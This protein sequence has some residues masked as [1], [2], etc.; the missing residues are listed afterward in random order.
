MLHHDHQ[1]EAG[2]F[3]GR[4]CSFKDKM[5]GINNKP[6]PFEDEAF[7]FGLAFAT[8]GNACAANASVVVFEAE[9]GNQIGAHDVAQSVLQLH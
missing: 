9:V 4:D 7:V 2:V 6:H 1:A 3:R 8:N 5:N